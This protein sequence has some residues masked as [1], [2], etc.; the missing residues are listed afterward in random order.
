MANRIISVHAGI[1]GMG[2]YAITLPSSGFSVAHSCCICDGNASDQLLPGR[3]EI[4]ADGSSAVIFLILIG[5][6]VKWSL[7]NRLKLYTTS[8]Q[9][10]IKWKAKKSINKPG[11]IW[12]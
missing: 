5:H 2:I 11:Q 9:R 1:Y 12:S 10:D 3:L 4:F 8:I 6:I 7:S